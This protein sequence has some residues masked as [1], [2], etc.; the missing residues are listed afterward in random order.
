V[1]CC[2]NR[3]AEG[4]FSFKNSSFPSFRADCESGPDAYNPDMLHTLN[5]LASRAVIERLVLLF[6]HVLASEPV[7][8]DRL[9]RHQ[10]SCM[11]LHFNDWPGVLPALPVLAFRITPA[12]LIEWCG[13]TFTETPTLHVRIDASNPAMAMA[14][15]LTGSRPKVEV[16]GDAAFAAELNWVFDNLRWDVEDDLARIVGQGP[17]RELARV[18]GGIAN[19][20]REAARVLGGLV[21][22]R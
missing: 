13:A 14:Q 1:P 15:A 6:N 16:S 7:A 21:A 18:A 19:G 17:A 11:Q 10:G 3:R 4:E 12:G 2:A 9:R 20:V 8:T 5:A 22:R